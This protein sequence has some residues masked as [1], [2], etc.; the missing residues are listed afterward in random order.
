M[1]LQQKPGTQGEYLCPEWM[2]WL[3]TQIAD[4][5]VVFMGVFVSLKSAFF[6]I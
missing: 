1:K 2:L 4:V 3:W 6:E 5:W